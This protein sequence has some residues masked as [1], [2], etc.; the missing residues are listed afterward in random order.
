M[1]IIEELNDKQKEAV[2]ATDGPC[3]V[4]AGAGSRKDKSFNTQDCLF[5]TRKAH[6]TMEHTCNYIYK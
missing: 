4:I 2:L 3:L 1:N 5:N 6:C